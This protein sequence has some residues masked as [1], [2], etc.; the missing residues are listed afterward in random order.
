MPPL[1]RKVPNQRTM[2]FSFQ[3][4]RERHILSIV[5]QRFED[6]LRAVS[7]F[8]CFVMTPLVV[9]VVTYF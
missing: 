2:R 7:Y 4:F 9:T 5:F 3:V 6:T 8:H 1:T